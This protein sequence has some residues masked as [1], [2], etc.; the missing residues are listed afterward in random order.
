M[1]RFK[2]NDPPFGQGGLGYKPRY[3]QRFITGGML[4]QETEQSLIDYRAGVHSKDKHS[5]PITEALEFYHN[6]VFS[7]EEMDEKVGNIVNSTDPKAKYYKA[8]LSHGQKKYDEVNPKPVK[9]KKEFKRHIAESLNNINGINMELEKNEAIIHCELKNIN[10]E[11][12]LVDVLKNDKGEKIYVDVLK[13]TISKKDKHTINKLSREQKSTLKA[14]LDALKYEG[15]Q[16]KKIQGLIN[17]GDIF[18][19]E[20]LIKLEYEDKEVNK[21]VL[22]KKIEDLD[23]EHG[24]AFEQVLENP[25]L[26]WIGA[27]KLLPSKDNVTHSY[28]NTKKLGDI[29]QVLYGKKIKLELSKEIIP[30]AEACVFDAF[31]KYYEIE[32]KNWDTNL[33]R[34]HFQQKQYR[35][36]TGKPLRDFP[37]SEGGEVCCFI[38]KRKLR[39][40]ISFEPYYYK[41]A[42]G[43]YKLY[44]VWCNAKRDGKIIGWMYGDKNVNRDVFAIFKFADGVYA[45][46][47]NQIVSTYSFK[48]V[49]DID[50]TFSG[51]PKPSVQLYYIEPT[52]LI[53]DNKYALLPISKFIKCNIKKE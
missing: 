22:D 20:D 6:P 11:W 26:L 33:F 47:I 18:T 31:N 10:G 34:V 32:F 3:N 24:E 51:I 52:E 35:E 9:I 4:R 14:L 8:L 25:N 2:S 50:L 16:R 37:I 48:E 29:N 36:G 13:R 1:M 21:D 28:T 15:G 38:Q 46:K 53:K 17:N 44:N 7:S 45:Y 39:Q 5:L 49:L 30:L 19:V 12:K 42:S 40:N 23:I 43:N 41:D 27:K